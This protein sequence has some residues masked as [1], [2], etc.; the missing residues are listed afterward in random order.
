MHVISRRRLNEFADAYPESRSALAHWYK[1]MKSANLEN[2][3]GIRAL[4]SGADR[5]GKLTVFN[6]GGNKVRIIVAV[7]YNRRKVY[8]RSVLTHS[9][10]DEDKWKE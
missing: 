8:I 3:A 6:V 9:E 4:F 7:H 5:I 2:F 10:Y 1:T